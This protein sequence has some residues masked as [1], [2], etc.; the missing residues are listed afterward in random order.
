MRKVLLE[1]VPCGVEVAVKFSRG[2]S[3]DEVC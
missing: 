1:W 2:T 3:S